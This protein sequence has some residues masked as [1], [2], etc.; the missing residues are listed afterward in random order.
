MDFVDN[1]GEDDRNFLLP[2]KACIQ[3]NC[4]FQPEHVPGSMRRVK[5]EMLSIA[6]RNKSYSG[7]I[8]QMWIEL[9][10][11]VESAIGRSQAMSLWNVELVLRED[12]KY[13]EKN[14]CTL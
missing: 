1:L 10:K 7:R 5:E 12:K 2:I 8:A 11:T 13:N 3:S 9:W 6:D 14:M 4:S